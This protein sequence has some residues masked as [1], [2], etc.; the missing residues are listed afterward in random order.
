MPSCAR[1][2]AINSTD[3][4]GFTMMSRASCNA[5]ALCPPTRLPVGAPK[6]AQNAGALEPRL[7][8]F[9]QRRWA[10]L[11]GFV[12]LAL[13][14]G[15]ICSIDSHGPFTS[16][17]SELAILHEVGGGFPELRREVLE[18][19]VAGRILPGSMALT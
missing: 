14:G 9:E 18:R 4:L 15:F 6:R 19:L 7:G 3:E 12:S 5:C 1:V 13:S 16:L 11:D 8:M 17:F 10:D 2:R